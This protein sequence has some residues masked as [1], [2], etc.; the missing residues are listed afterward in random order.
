MFSYEKQ[1]NKRPEPEVFNVPTAAF[2][3]GDFSAILG[4]QQT[5]TVTQANSCAGPV[6]TVVLLTNRDGSPALLNQ[7]YDPATAQSVTRCNPLTGTVQTNIERLPFAGNVI[8]QAR[9]NPAALRFLNLYPLP[10]QPGIQNGTVDNYFSNQ[11]NIQPYDSYLTRID[12]NINANNRIFG[13]FFWSKSTEDRYNWLDEDGSVTQGFEIRRNIGGNIDY[14]ATLSSNLVFDLRGSY[15]NFVQDRIAPNALSAADLGF[16]GIAAISESTVYPRFDFTNYDTLGAERADFNEGLTRTYRLFSVQPTLTQIFGDHTLKYGYDFRRIREDRVTN[17][18][19]AGRFLFNGTYTAQASNTSST[20]VNLVGRDLASF[21]LGIPAASASGS[22]IEQAASYDVSE[23][24]HGFFIQDDW[25]I[26]QR[27][28]LN[29]GLRYELET[30]V[31]ERNG[32]MVVGFDTTAESPLRAGALANYNANVPA[33]VPINAFQNLS[34]GLQFATDPSQRNQAADKN[35][36]QPRIGISYALDDKTILRGGFGI[37]TA[38]FQIQPINQAGFTANTAFTPTTNNGLTFIADIN[39][40]FPNGTNP[41]VGAGLGLNTLVGTTLGTTNASGPTDA[42]LYT[43]DRKNANYIRFIAGV[44]RQLPWDI[45]AEATFV[46]SKGQDLP[47]LRQLNYIPREYLNDFTGVDPSTIAARITATQTFLNQTVPNPFRGLVPQNGTLNANTI[48][49]RF[50]LTQY[51]QFQDVIVTEYNGSSD[52]RSL[53]LQLTK[54]MSRGLSFNASYTYTHDRE[55]TRRLNPQD[56]ELTDMISTLSRPHRFALSTVFELPVGRKRQFLSEVH[57]IVD[58]F[59]GGWQLNAVFERQS[60][61]PLVLPN[62]YYNGNIEDLEIDIGGYTPNGLRKGVDVPAFDISGFRIN[63]VVPG[64]S[65]NYTISSQNVLRTLPYT[66]N[67][68]RN[69]PFQKFDLGLT[70]NFSIREG[71][72]LQVRIEAINALNTVYFSGIQLAASNAAFG[73][74]NT[75]RNLPRDIQL[76]ARFT[77]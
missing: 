27:L 51:P 65:N 9:I 50:L 16:N 19:N 48:Q 75:Q 72:K 29:L 24:Y 71:M 3:N 18:Y 13:K 49:R 26:S 44:Q 76:G 42:T 35:N 36:F 22:F 59:L 55:K 30:G 31:R 70:K 69:Q 52:Y 58:A 28:T 67:N 45:G 73:L 32:Q 33:S 77:F 14:T 63:G 4:G 47:V 39:N 60:G 54:R 25:R 37:F 74:V 64:Y 20:I 34:G 38:P 68:F 46:Y 56:E 53:Q 57:P 15:N 40:P 61:E 1:Y 7:I 2:R 43:Y 21:L 8:P 12:H 10:N 17:G 41:A 11:T 66:T 62:L 5:F 23:L 6:G